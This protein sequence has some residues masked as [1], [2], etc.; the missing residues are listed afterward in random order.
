MATNN[1]INWEWLLETGRIQ[2][3]SPGEDYVLVGSFDSGKKTSSTA[4]RT[5][6]YMIKVSDFLAAT[7]GGTFEALSDTPSYSGNGLKG[8]RINAAEDAV[9]AYVATDLNQWLITD[10]AFVDPANGNDGTAIVGDGNLPYSTITAAMA[11]AD[12]VLLLPADYVETVS[13]TLNNKHIHAMSGV[14]FSAGGIRITGAGVTSFRF[15]GDAVFTG[16]SR[17]LRVYSLNAVV[18]FECDYID[19]RLVLW[20]ESD[21]V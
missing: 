8:L 16:T 10:V 3:A 20:I 2:E 12:I 9:E 15:S 7:G 5:R 21:T 6:E 19:N 4:S 14:D 17:T 11:V 1:I 13:V 18:D